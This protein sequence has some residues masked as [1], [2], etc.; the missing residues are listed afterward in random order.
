MKTLSPKSTARK[1]IEQTEALRKFLEQF[2]F[3]MVEMKPR[4]IVTK[5]KKQIR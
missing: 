3:D 4:S 1:R 2:Y 5:T